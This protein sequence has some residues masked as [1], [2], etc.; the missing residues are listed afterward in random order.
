MSA[1]GSSL[2]T[3]GVFAVVFAF[4]YAVA[5]ALALFLPVWSLSY[6]LLWTSIAAVMN[7]GMYFMAD[8]LVL[9]SYG[10]R[11]VSQGDAPGLHALVGEV[12]EACGLPAPKVAIMNEPSPN[13]FA[14]GRN[15]QHS[16]VC[17]TTGILGLLNEHELRGVV[18]HELSHVKNR[19]TL[20]MT[21]VATVAAFFAYMIQFGGA[22]AT[23]RSDRGSGLLGYLAFAI[24]GSVAALLL[25]AFVSRRREYG[26]DAAGAAI[27]HDS[28]GLANALL[29]LDYASRG[30]P[31]RV[32]RDASAHLFI[33]NPITWRR[34][35]G[36]AQSHPPIQ[37]RV[38]R[39]ERMGF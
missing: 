7:I 6:I 34:A 2:K 24:L 33:V 1:V 11:V 20:V 38:R 26:A 31:M 21:A 39:L 23:G 13:A 36:L 10:A 17:F 18:A 4:V 27:L 29:K 14:T 15:P 12:A 30:R 8:R 25:R 16:V 28:S 22:A 37:D 35:A 3:V 5:G 9:A 19:D 32:A